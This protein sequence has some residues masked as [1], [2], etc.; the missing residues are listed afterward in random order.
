MKDIY[1]IINDNTGLYLIGYSEVSDNCLWGNSDNAI[2]FD[3]LDAAQSV[4]NTINGGGSGGI[5]P[6]LQP[7]H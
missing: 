1:V 7:S 5:R 6:V 3:S 4:A 2:T